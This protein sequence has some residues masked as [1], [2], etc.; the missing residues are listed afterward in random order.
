MNKR[1]TQRKAHCAARMRQGSSGAEMSVPKDVKSKLH[2][3]S[4]PT[5]AGLNMHDGI[6]LIHHKDAIFPF[7]EE[8]NLGRHDEDGMVT[9]EGVFETVYSLNLE[10]S[11]LWQQLLGISKAPYGII[12]IPILTVFGIRYHLTIKCIWD[13]S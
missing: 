12:A 9:S 4:V 1:L 13:E 6:I 2:M 3:I 10:F 8:V 5:C 7:V 11:P